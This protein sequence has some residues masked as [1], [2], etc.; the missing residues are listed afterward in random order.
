MLNV[1]GNEM[2]LEQC[3]AKVL[4]DLFDDHEDPIFLK[5]KSRMETVCCVQGPPTA[6]ISDVQAAMRNVRNILNK[7]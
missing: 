1:K 6:C 7:I 5:V 3:V 2:T 4:V